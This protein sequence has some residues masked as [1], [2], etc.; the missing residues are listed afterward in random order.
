MTTRPLLLLQHTEHWVAVDKPPGLPVIPSR[1]PQEPCLQHRLQAQ[2]GQRLWV[3]HR[4]DRDTSGVVLLACHA[5]AHRALC[6][7]FEQHRLRKTYR[8]WAWGALDAQ[9]DIRIPLHSAR[10]SRMRPA[11]PGEPD[12]LPAHSTVRPQRRFHHPAGP[13]TELEVDLHTGRQHQI[14]VHLRA[15]GHPLVGDVIYG[16]AFA[17]ADGPTPPRLGLHAEHLQ[18]LEP[19]L[20]QTLAVTA[21]RPIDLQRWLATLAVT[22]G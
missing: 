1:D 7:A 18:S 14:R 8:A 9:Q 2:M 19:I 21:P 13:V 12:A 17:S 20:G 6:M 10:K 11:L 22:A 3:V 5:Q 16:R 4:I 15:I